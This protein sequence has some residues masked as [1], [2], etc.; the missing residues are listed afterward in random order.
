MDR[1]RQSKH[2][3][4]DMTTGDP[5]KHILLFALPALIGNVFQQVYNLSDSVIVGRFVGPDALAAVGSSSSLVF[6]FFALCTGIGN[7]GG[8]VVS[9]FY[10]AGDAANVKKCIVNTGLI[11]LIVPV[12]V[13]SLGYAFAP[14]ILRILD[15]PADIL[16]DSTLYI[17]YM[18][19]GL[20]FVSLYNYLAAMLRALGDSRTP[21]YFLI[22][23]TLL[24]VGL[25]IMLVYNFKMGVKGVALATIT[26]QLISALSC[27]IYAIRVNPYFKLK[28]SDFVFSG[29]MLYSVIRL[30][31][32]MSLQFGLISISSMAVQRVVNS[33]G[34][35]VIAAFTATNRIEQ[36]IHQP[37]TTLG[38]S[39]ATYSGQNYGAKKLDRVYDG[40]KKGFLIMFVLTAFMILTMQ[41]FGGAI[42][43]MFVTDPQV[44]ALGKT[45][46][47]ITSLFYPA[48]G[49]IYVIR[50]VLTGV[51]DAFFALFN[52]IVE[53]IGRFTLPILMTKYMGMGATGIWVSAGVVWIVSGI[54]AWMRYRAY[55]YHRIKPS[56]TSSSS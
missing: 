53:V 54:T 34:T 51:G 17:R 16:P 35:I 29:N 49:A 32:P 23:S 15:T 30:G 21:L 12:I 22:V 46:L 55:L 47:R 33:Y 39:L 7:G 11:M 43:G 9:Q 44:I 45:G 10:G 50:G 5:V 13:G 25:D 36:L 1:T 18:S 20:L 41:L 40:Y 28:R 4:M 48:L 31:V 56:A 27:G 19:I 42:T 26:A 38:A 8:I 24:N 2:H 37:Y 52:G 6:L 3:M 14:S